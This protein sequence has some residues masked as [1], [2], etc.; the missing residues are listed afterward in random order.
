[1]HQEILKKEKQ[2]PVKGLIFVLEI[3]A[4][5]F[6]A[7]IGSNMV[8][9]ILHVS[10]THYIVYILI[11]MF[12]V[13]LLRNELS[14]FQY[15]LQSDKIWFERKIGIRLIGLLQINMEDVL[16]FGT[17][18]ECPYKIWYISHYTYLKKA[19]GYCIVYKANEKVKF[20]LFHPSE[21]LIEKLN[22]TIHVS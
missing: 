21:K 3:V 16:W 4:V 9:N 10:Y 11:I 22:A 17:Y 18:K 15:T 12:A 7:M 19:S 6:A 14:A 8:Y 1:M 20:I 5:L 13:Y 2:S